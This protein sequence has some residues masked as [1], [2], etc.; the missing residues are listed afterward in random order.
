M[1]WDN[2]ALDATLESRLP[3]TPAKGKAIYIAGR[4]GMAFEGMGLAS[5]E[6]IFQHKAPADLHWKLVPY[7]DETHDSLKLKATYDALKF[8][9]QGYTSDTIEVVPDEGILIKGKPIAVHVGNERFDIH[10]ATDGSVP[11]AS[12]PRAVETIFISDPEMTTIKLFSAR[13]AFDRVIPHGLRSGIAMS[14]ERHS[15]RGDDKVWRYTIYP[16]Q[17]W[18][19][20][21]G[22]KPLQT[23]DMDR[24]MDLGQTGY[25]DFVGALER[26][27]NIPSDG[28][29]IFRVY[30]SD[31]ARLSLSGKL[32]ITIDA[33][34]GPRE[35]AFVVPLRRGSYHARLEFQHPSK[36]SGVGLSVFQNKNGETEWW[37][38]E[39]F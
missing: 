16:A 30:S 37:K 38:N 33:A 11:D 35:H 12:S 3:G 8:A 19:I 26:N 2:H 15:T 18:P 6:P 1:S 39:I 20:V 29:Y 9:Y 28:Y 31:Q 10:Y 25:E 13:G 24:G 7:P 5:I 32:L 34:H 14:P 36:T 21:A 22:A 27:L 23:G 4:S 17:S